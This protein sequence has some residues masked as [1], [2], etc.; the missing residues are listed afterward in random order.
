[1]QMMQRVLL[2]RRDLQLGR[3]RHCSLALKPTLMCIQY[4]FSEHGDADDWQARTPLLST[5]L[6][7]HIDVDIR[8]EYVVIDHFICITRT[9]DK[10]NCDWSLD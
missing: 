4:K 5:L 1:V 7:R 9:V 8:E 2:V 6:G 10:H 3:H